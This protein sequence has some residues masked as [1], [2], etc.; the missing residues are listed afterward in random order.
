M[1]RMRTNETIIFELSISIN[2]PEQAVSHFCVQIPP[3]RSE[4]ACKLAKCANIEFWEDVGSVVTP[5]SSPV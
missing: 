2:T 5:F 3:E 4:I 1:P